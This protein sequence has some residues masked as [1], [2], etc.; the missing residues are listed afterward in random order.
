MVERVH[1]SCFGKSMATIEDINNRIIT[2]SLC[3]IWDSGICH[4][5]TVFQV[6]PEGHFRGSDS[7]KFLCTLTQTPPCHFMSPRVTEQLEN[8]ES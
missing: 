5:R 8:T 3:Y 7:R 6:F 2:L 1:F 4:L